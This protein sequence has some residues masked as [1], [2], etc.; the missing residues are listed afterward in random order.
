MQR[1]RVG[2][3]VS[4]GGGEVTWDHGIGSSPF[5]THGKD[6]LEPSSHG[7]PLRGGPGS[8]Y[9]SL[10]CAFRSDVHEGAPP[11]VVDGHCF[12]DWVSSRFVTCS[13]KLEGIS[14]RWI[15]VKGDSRLLERAE[16]TAD[17]NIVWLRTLLGEPR[18]LVLLNKMTPLALSKY[19]VLLPFCGRTD[20]ADAI[21]VWLRTLLG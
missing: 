20:I 8:T 1:G 14:P 10:F 11:R 15:L 3:W 7:P 21:V 5:R 12:E 13:G 19:V 16:V 18:R 17:A 2:R 9:F 4:W 6:E